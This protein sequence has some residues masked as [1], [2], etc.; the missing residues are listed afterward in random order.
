MVLGIWHTNDSMLCL[1][2][3]K[4]ISYDCNSAVPTR[5]SIKNFNKKSVIILKVLT[6]NESEMILS[7]PSDIR[8]N[9]RLIKQI[10]K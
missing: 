2:N 1:F 10:K 7:S 9:I 5:V 6:V 8:K 3:Q 4:S